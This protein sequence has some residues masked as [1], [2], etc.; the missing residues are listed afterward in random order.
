M[1]HVF[2]IEDIDNSCSQETCFKWDSMAHLNLI[3]ELEDVFDISLEP[4]EIAEMTSYESVFRIVS[5]KLK[6]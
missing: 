1:K 3:L 6:R 5:K 4:E 2:G